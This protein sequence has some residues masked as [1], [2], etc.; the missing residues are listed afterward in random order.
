MS[1]K[2]WLIHDEISRSNERLLGEYCTPWNNQD[3]E[4]RVWKK[5]DSHERLLIIIIVWL[6][7]AF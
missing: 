3:G 2:E 1:L 6:N 7:R 5:D 4:S